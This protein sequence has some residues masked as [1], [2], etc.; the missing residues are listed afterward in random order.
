M[1]QKA[2]KN[3]F[4][5][6]NVRNIKDKPVLENHKTFFSTVRLATMKELISED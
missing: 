4:N 6:L 1:I 2:K 3:Y 5:N